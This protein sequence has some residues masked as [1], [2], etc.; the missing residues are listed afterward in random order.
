M[1][2][3]AN[4]SVSLDTDGQS[5][6]ARGISFILVAPFSIPKA[7]ANVICMGICV[8]SSWCGAKTTG[9]YAHPV[10]TIR[11]LCDV[12]MPCPLLLLLVPAL[13]LVVTVTWRNQCSSLPN[14]LREFYPLPAAHKFNLPMSVHKSMQQNGNNSI[15]NTL[16]HTHTHGGTRIL[17]VFVCCR[18]RD[19]EDGATCVWR[20]ADKKH[21]IKRIEIALW[22]LWAVEW[23]DLQWPLP[24]EGMKTSGVEKNKKTPASG[25][26]KCRWGHQFLLFKHWRKI[27]ANDDISTWHCSNVC[28]NLFIHSNWGSYKWIFYSTW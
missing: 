6:D 12:L 28:L 3:W 4:P 14:S 16:T 10:C 8:R 23:C 26:G 17:C 11:A 9:F 1:V 25:W 21:S 24:M 27:W 20:L 13:V 22:K 19:S 5:A 2:T 18:A 7:P 15:R